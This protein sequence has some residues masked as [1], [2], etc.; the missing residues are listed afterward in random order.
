MPPS[1]PG[2]QSAPGSL[3]RSLAAK[4]AHRLPGYKEKLEATGAPG[5]AVDDPAELFKA[6]VFETPLPLLVSEVPAPERPTR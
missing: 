5:E 3:L 6:L 1:Q 4:L 2:A